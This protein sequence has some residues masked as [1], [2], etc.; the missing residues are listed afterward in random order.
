MTENNALDAVRRFFNVIARPRTYG[1]LAYV[2]LAFPL[3]LLYF[4]FLVTGSALSIGLSLLWIGLL[5]MVA[6][7]LSIWALSQFERGLSKWLLGERISGKH[8]DAPPAPT[9][10][11]WLTNILKDWS[12]WR[13]ALFLLLKFPIGLI[14]WT[15]SVVTL[16]L[17]FAFMAAPFA[18]YQGEIDFGLWSLQDPT[19]G[20]L[21]TLFGILLLFPVLHLHNFMGMF[22]RLMSRYLLTVRPAGEPTDSD[23]SAPP[24]A[25]LLD[26]AHP[27][28][29]F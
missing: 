23:P 29:S 19:G 3:G 25:I 15:V 8:A 4:V 12:T 24:T 7:V 28:V 10:W 1:N 22:F 18:T 17:S 26:A 14:C 5:V 21:M 27:A 9:R 2:W 16:S 11:I 13:G 6:F 20:W